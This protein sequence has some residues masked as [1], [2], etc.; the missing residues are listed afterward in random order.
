MSKTPS[1]PIMTALSL[2]LLVM[3]CKRDGSDPAAPPDA[4]PELAPGAEQAPEDDGAG[5]VVDA[6]AIGGDVGRLLRGLRL[7]GGRLELAGGD[8]WRV[9]HAFGDPLNWTGTEPTGV[10]LRRGWPSQSSGSRM[11]VRSGWPSN[12]TPNMS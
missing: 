2:A 4:K 6:A 8:V 9:A 11:R 3:A 10:S 12:S 1:V 7:G 5:G